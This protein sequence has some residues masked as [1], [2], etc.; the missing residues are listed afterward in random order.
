[1]LQNEYLVAFVAVNTAENEPSKVCLYLSLVCLYLVLRDFP[2]RDRATPRREVLDSKGIGLR[3]RPDWANVAAKLAVH[4]LSP[5]CG[6]PTQRG[7]SRQAGYHFRETSSMENFK[8]LRNYT[9]FFCVF[10]SSFTR[11]DLDPTF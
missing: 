6:L 9:N 4:S 5:L 1:M 3:K 2:R 10:F 8:P 7:K 11:S